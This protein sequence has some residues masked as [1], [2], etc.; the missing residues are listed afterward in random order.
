MTDPGRSYHLTEAAVQHDPNARSR[1]L[2]A[3]F[4]AAFT[5][6]LAI[7]AA[8]PMVAM[9]MELRGMSASNIGYVVAGAPLGLILMSP[10]MG[11]LV[12]RFGLLGAML[13]GT[14]LIVATLVVMPSVYGVVPWVICR[15]IAGLGVAAIWILSETWV[16][17]LA[18]NEDRGKIV[19]GFMITMSCGFGLGPLAVTA[20]GVETWTPFYLAAGVISISIIPLWLARDVAPTLPKS[21]GWSFGIALRTAPLLMMIALFA[22]VTD[23]TQLSF[24]PVYAVREGFSADMALYMLT[25][26]ILGSLLVQVPLGIL[27]DKLGRNGLMA[28]FLVLTI[29][30]GGAIPFVLHESFL[31]WPILVMWG[32]VAFGLYTL[33]IIT[34]GDRFDAA[35]LAGA[36]AALV[37][38]YELGSIAGPVAVGHAM[39]AYGP[40]GMPVVLVLS[41]IPVMIYFVIRRLRRP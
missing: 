14:A 41:G 36:N 10:F 13:L 40:N 35:S 33:C 39:D 30:L 1:A 19:S 2:T 38:F 16:N 37:A 5:A 8:L 25:A 6:G 17:A 20:I 24:Y 4:V 34:L 7:G 21:D 22:G 11:A 29:V 27:V 23:A 32:G 26:I 12:N 31:I 18:T 15:V 28:I 9:T 3:I